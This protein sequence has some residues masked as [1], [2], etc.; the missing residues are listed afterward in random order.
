MNTRQQQKRQTRR[1]LMDAALNL[2]ADG[3]PFAS[4]G[5]REIT[6][7]AGLSAPAFYRHF[8]DMD[9]LGLA[10]VDEAGVALRQLMRDARQRV[11]EDGQAIPTSI[12]TFV[13][14]LD[15]RAPEFRLIVS[16]SHGGSP[17]FRQAIA[18]ERDDF[19]K[20]LADDLHRMAEHRGRPVRGRHALAEAM[21]TLVFAAGARMLDED[22][23][24][25][26]RHM[27]QLALQLRMAQ[28]GA[29]TLVARDATVTGD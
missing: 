27:A 14:Y 11:S 9:A 5:L 22:R 23:D 25:R 1:A 18:R 13:E 12:K 29:E 26:V 28:L 24:E 8:D 2:L 20:E 15:R 10:L 21:V 17:A 7:G 3:R 19:A 4:L 6:R 16:Q